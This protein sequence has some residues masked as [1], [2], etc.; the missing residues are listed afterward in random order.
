[1]PVVVRPTIYDTD[2]FVNDNIPIVVDDVKLNVDDTLFIF[3]RRF[4][5]NSVIITITSIIILNVVYMHFGYFQNGIKNPDMV[6]VYLFAIVFLIG[7]L[8]MESDKYGG[9]VYEQESLLAIEQMNSLLLGSLVIIIYFG[10]DIV[11]D[12]RLLRVSLVLLLLNSLNIAVI[13]DGDRIKTIR[14]WKEG[15][16][17]FAIFLIV[18]STVVEYNSSKP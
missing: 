17:N 18:C 7:R 2:D 16:L 6:V 8:I 15:V 9:F 3:G 14:T 13:E 4:D 12:K 1:M 5:K 10:N 11:G